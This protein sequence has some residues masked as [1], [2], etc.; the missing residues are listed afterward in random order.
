[1]STPTISPDSGENSIYGCEKLGIA[2]KLTILHVT[3]ILTTNAGSLLAFLYEEKART[4]FYNY[5]F[6]SVTCIVLNSKNI[7]IH[8]SYNSDVLAFKK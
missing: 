3:K 4:P 6:L 8:A 2:N 5:V 7:F 1:M